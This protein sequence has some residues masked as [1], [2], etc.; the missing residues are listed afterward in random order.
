[1]FF[2][3]N[4]VRDRRQGQ[5]VQTQPNGQKQSGKWYNDNFI[6][7][8]VQTQRYTIDLSFTDKNETEQQ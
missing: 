6:G 3:G 4:W 7:N 5:G 8:D 1:M 2:L